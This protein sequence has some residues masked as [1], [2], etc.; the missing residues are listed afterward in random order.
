[1]CSVGA[2]PASRA[3]ETEAEACRTNPVQQAGSILKIQFT[4]L[5]REAGMGRGGSLE[6]GCCTLQ[7]LPPWKKKEGKRKAALCR[8]AF[9]REDSAG[10]VL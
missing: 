1:M 8:N 9:A 3:H 6:Q 7:P 2:E 5:A 10:S 4:S